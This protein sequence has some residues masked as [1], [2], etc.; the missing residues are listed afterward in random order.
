MEGETRETVIAQMQLFHER[1]LPTLDD[2]IKCGNSLIDFDIYSKFPDLSDDIKIKRR[3]NAFS[4]KTSFRQIFQGEGFDIVIGNPPWISLT[5]RFGNDI[6]T[7]EAQQYLIDKYS[8]NTYMPNLYEYFVSKGFTLFKPAGLFSFIVPDRLGFNGQFISMRNI[9]LTKYCLNELIYKAP[10]PDITTDTLIFKIT[11]RQADETVKICEWGKEF[12]IKKTADMVSDSEHKFSYE[13]S[14]AIA[15]VLNKIFVHPKSKQLGIIADT[16][17]G[18]GG[19][20]DKLTNERMNR[21][22][23]EVLRGRSIQKYAL[24]KKYFFEF[25]DDFITGRTRDEEKLAASP[26]V[27]LRKTGVPLFAT[28]DESGIYPEQ[29]LY[30]IFNNKTDNS[31]KYLTALL[32]SNVFQFVYLHKL[33]T[34]KDSTPQLKKTDLDIFPTYIFDLENAND[35][36]EHAAMIESV[37]SLLAAN[38]QLYQI[39]DEQLKEQLLQEC[40]FHEDRIN[41]LVY[42]IYGLSGD[43]INTIEGNLKLEK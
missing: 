39:N 33:V 25:R 7:E 36:T 5:G 21:R 20:A 6:L 11:N 16:T 28:Y 24:V 42:K 15:L 38:S 43:E 14:D 40:N 4:W 2:N 27:L 8:G 9:I 34:N 31:L 35:A 12:Q 17:S 10:F 30:F 23:I 29:S 3:I 19:Q 26:K 22:Q 41:R 1:L 13:L 37:D 18:F 32:N